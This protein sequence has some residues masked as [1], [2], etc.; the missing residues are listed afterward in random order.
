MRQNPD[1]FEDAQETIENNRG[2]AWMATTLPEIVSRIKATPA[3]DTLDIATKVI[4]SD[5]IIK[6]NR[7]VLF[8]KSR[9][10]LSN[11]DSEFIAIACKELILDIPAPVNGNNR[12]VISRQED[13]SFEDRIAV[14][15]RGSD[16][17]D[18][19]PGKGGKGHHKRRGLDGDRGEDG[20]SGG[21]G[22]RM[23]LPDLYFFVQQV[24]LGG[25]TPS[26]TELLTF[27]FTGL[28]GGS[29]GTGGNGGRG[30]K[31]ARGQKAASSAVDCKAGG[32]DGGNGGV[33][34]MGGPGGPGADGGSGAT[35]VFCSPIPDILKFFSVV[36][37]GGRSGSGGAPGKG[38]FGGK[39][40]E[41][42]RGDLH[43]DGG[44]PGRDRSAERSGDYG[45]GQDGQNGDDGR[46]FNLRR[47]NED[48][49]R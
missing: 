2:R 49:F 17:S 4:R 14:G 40:G 32:G 7:L 22:K 1:A 31:G 34:G 12:A 45:R 21:E 19:R 38:G 41:G 47:D 18:G 13:R 25:Q 30:G 28:T 33:G 48:L 3:E 29:G 11:I 6:C 36:Q 46:K 35:I 43:C 39:G 27:R 23:D 9:L 16:G 24:V 20:R 10:I 8:S 42:G 26:D 5:Q 44:R 37:I 15:L